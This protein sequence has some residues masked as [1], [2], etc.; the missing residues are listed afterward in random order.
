MAT[1]EARRPRKEFTG[2]VRSAAMDKS[3]VVEIVTPRKDRLYRKYVKST[4]RV[5]A[6]DEKNAAGVGDRVRVVECRPLSRRKRWRLAEILEKAR[7]KGSG[8]EAGAGQ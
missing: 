6:H 2:T 7:G 1:E 4:K 5:M 3:I 8:A